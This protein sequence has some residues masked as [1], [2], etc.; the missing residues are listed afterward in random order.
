MNDIRLR[1]LESL[2]TDD[3]ESSSPLLSSQNST[4]NESIRRRDTDGWDP[5]QVL[6]YV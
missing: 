4:K 1:T 3:A 5:K 2:K 6:L